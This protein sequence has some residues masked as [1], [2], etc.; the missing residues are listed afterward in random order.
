MGISKS[1]YGKNPTKRGS[2]PPTYR[3]LFNECE[4]NKIHIRKHGIN[5]TIMN[6]DNTAATTYR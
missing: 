2:E 5:G 6:I 1:P 3:S 4:K